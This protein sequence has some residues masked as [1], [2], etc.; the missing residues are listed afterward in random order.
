MSSYLSIAFSLISAIKSFLYSRVILLGSPYSKT[1][2]SRTS[3][4][5]FFLSAKGVERYP[6]TAAY[7]LAISNFSESVSFLFTLNYSRIGKSDNDKSSILS[8]FYYKMS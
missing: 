6:A 4:G 3:F 7:L 8:L 5:I 1:I 2:F